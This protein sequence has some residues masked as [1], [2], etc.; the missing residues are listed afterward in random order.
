[1]L[2][3]A[4][5]LAQS[6]PAPMPVDDEPSALACT[7]EAA[8][9][10]ARCLFEASSAPGLP[11][12]NSQVAA[13]AG[14]RACAAV[15]NRDE[16]LRKE[17]EKAVAEASLGAKCSVAARLA[18]S[19]GRLTVEARGCVEAVREAVSRTARA[20]A[21]P[22]DCCKCLGAARCAVPATQCRRELADLVPGAALQSC[23]SRS[24]RDACAFS[25]EPLP[26]R[27]PAAPQQ[28]QA[29]KI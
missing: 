1:M 28:T 3:L 5:L 14:L 18:D 8:L 2:L 27:S 7:F 16:G 26:A 19:R 10:G 23:M 12:D 17:C 20:A 15:S 24:C 25:A 13:D 22:G 9:G 29:D 21:L 4:L 6:I 11:R